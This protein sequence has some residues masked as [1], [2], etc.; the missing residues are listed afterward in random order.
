MD[1][2]DFEISNDDGLR[3]A[4]YEI[5]W[6]NTKWF[7]TSADQEIV[8]TIPV[9]A[10]TEDR[11]YLP[12]AISDSGMKQGG[13]NNDM[14]VNAPSNI[15]LVDLFVSTPPALE[16]W[17]TVR[18]MHL[19]QTDTPKIAWTGTINN[20]KRTEGNAEVEIIGH[21]LLA[22][23]KRSGLRLA[24]TRGCPHMLY[25]QDCKADK[26]LFAV[27]GTITALTG[28]TI[29]VDFTGPDPA[30][31]WFD[32]GFI[33]WVADTGTGTIDRRGVVS[34]SS[35]TVLTLFGT[36]Y[37]LAVGMAITLYPGCDLT[38][39]TCDAKFSNGDNFGG[40]EQMTGKNPFDGTAI[41]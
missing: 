2:E 5:E 35:A 26:T 7:Y 27:A 39:A 16:I 9:G 29:T 1:F 8:A 10:G 6:G 40:L 34:S 28:N 4:L 33:E 32:G 17:L 13:G 14:T 20:V 36:T 37:R 18:R 21:S 12:V 19:G 22:S 38:K 23:F 11:T 24:W 15:P 41:I 30:A 31:G 3:I 25:D